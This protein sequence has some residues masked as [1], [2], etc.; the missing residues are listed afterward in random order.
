[1]LSFGLTNAPATFQA[2]MKRL[3]K[4]VFG[5]FVM[6]YLSADG[7]RVDLSK[8]PAVLNWPVPHDIPQMDP[9]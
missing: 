9:P 7:L 5:K 2:V 8:I 3:F 4:D 6:F 1:M